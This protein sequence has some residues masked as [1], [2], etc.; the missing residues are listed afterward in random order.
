[1]LTFGSLFSG[2]GGLD[3]GF[4]RA[5]L[6][7]VWQVEKDD[8]CRKVLR[9]HWPNVPQWDDVTTFT[10]EGFERP[11]VIAGGFPCQDLSLAGKRGG[12]EG[13]RSGLWW[14]FAR[15][16]RILRPRYVV[17]ENVPGIAIPVGPGRPAP[18]GC[19]LGE[20]AHLGFDAEWSPIS[21]RSLGSTQLRRRV[22]IIAYPKGQRGRPG[23]LST[24]QRTGGQGAIDLEGAGE[25]PGGKINIDRTGL[26]GRSAQR[27][28]LVKGRQAIERVCA[29]AGDDPDVNRDGSGQGAQESGDES[30]KRGPSGQPDRC[31]S[32]FIGSGWWGSEP[33][34]E[35]MVYGIPRRLVR[36]TI[37][38]LG[39]AVVPQVAEVVAKRLLK[40]AEEQ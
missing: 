19:V 39:N 5:G 17:I 22:F 38:A 32:P 36:D 8:F 27:G 10:G 18:L 35:R 1:M 23:R 13:E 11:D 20:L 2:V 12:L 37:R 4:E 30:R 9:K 21:A 6:K 26:Q 31:D 28:N 7:C 15:I 40:I 14:E 16:I 29:E 3:L 25:I 24:G 34:L 33:A